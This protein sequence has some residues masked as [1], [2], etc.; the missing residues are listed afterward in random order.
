[1]IQ[2]CF[3][4]SDNR[5]KFPK[6][7]N[8]TLYAYYMIDF[9]DYFGDIAN[10]RHKEIKNNLSEIF[11]SI[12]FEKEKTPRESNRRREFYFNNKADEAHFMLWVSNKNKKAV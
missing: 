1:M 12:K 8:K 9:N 7:G 2:L 10:Q 4:K 6:I 3:R 5:D 11:K